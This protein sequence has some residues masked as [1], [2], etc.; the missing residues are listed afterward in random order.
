M[1]QKA[2]F[3]QLIQ[4]T[5]KNTGKNSSRKKDTKFLSYCQGDFTVGS[6]GPKKQNKTSSCDF[7]NGVSVIREKVI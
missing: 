5:R 1:Q 2:P 3:D 7:K 6:V 4:Q